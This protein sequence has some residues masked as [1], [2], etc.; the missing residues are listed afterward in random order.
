MPKLIIIALGII[1]L[2]ILA[3]L[4]PATR[5]IVGGTLIAVTICVAAYREQQRTTAAVREVIDLAERWERR[6]E[7]FHLR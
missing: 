5:D 2:G 3:A 1:A 6:A 7:R 4:I